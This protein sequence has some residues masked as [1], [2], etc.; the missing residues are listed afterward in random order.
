MPIEF[1]T[2]VFN[3]LTAGLPT[4][5]V[6]ERQATYQAG[7]PQA[8]VV[9]Y[10]VDYSA[11]GEQQGRIQT[12]TLDI[13]VWDNGPDATGAEETADAIERMVAEWSVETDRQ[14]R[15]RM[16]SSFSRSYVDEPNE[17]LAHVTMRFTGRC[18]RRLEH[19]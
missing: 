5:T 12:V 18:F 15:V 10:S 16:S 11:A 14:G 13:D 7:G 17:K 6:S 8:G 1:S 19:V 2:A 9:T 3:L 4:L